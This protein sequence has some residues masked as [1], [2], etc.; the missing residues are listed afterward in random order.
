MESNPPVTAYIGLG[1]NLGDAPQQLAA[2]AGS[3]ALLP[4]T[5]L[6]ALSHLYRSAAIEVDTPQPDYYN[7]VAV[8]DTQLGAEAL[9]TALLAIEAHFGR[10]R[11]GYH[12]PR[13]L[14]LDLLLYGNERYTLPH[15]T[16]PHPRLHQRAFVL[17][18]LLE[19]TPELTAPGLGRLLDYLPAVAAQPITRVAPLTATEPTRFQPIEALAP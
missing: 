1:A 9:L 8:L 7:A 16:V 2:A 18:P 4:H 3:L 19:L 12:S 14:D 6:V 17:L 10:I 15:L 5:E 11:T 13:T